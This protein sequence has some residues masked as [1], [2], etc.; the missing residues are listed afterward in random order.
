MDQ[1]I[2]QNMDQNIEF[3]NYIYQNAEMGTTTIKKIL[4]IVKDDDLST[5]LKT[6]LTEYENIFDASKQK[7]NI[8]GH[9]EKDIGTLQK[10]TAN[11]SINLSTLTDKSNSHIAEMLLQGS[12]MGVIDA[13]KNIKKYPDANNDIK[14]LAYRLL[15][16]EENNLE[17]L[18]K[19]L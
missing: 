18:K 5:H 7:L 12:L 11:F 9:K 10:I 17:S 13:T 6:Q 4:D 2:N 16:T 1:N 14:D 19:F 3:L 15:K 8:A